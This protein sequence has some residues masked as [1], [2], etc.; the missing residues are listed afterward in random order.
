MRVFFAI[1]RLSTSLSNG[2]TILGD[3]ILFFPSLLFEVTAVS[4]QAQCTPHFVT[5]SISILV[6]SI[7]PFFS[8]H[9]AKLI[10]PYDLINHT[11]LHPYHLYCRFSQVPGWTRPLQ[12][13]RRQARF[14]LCPSL[15][16][17]VFAIMPRQ[18]I[19]PWVVCF[20]ADT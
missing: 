2:P 8:S 16:D 1:S 14:F 10:W 9:M 3:S 17:V 11:M 7:S 5:H 12:R 4:C 13:L 19:L 15:C 6:P 18:V 20:D